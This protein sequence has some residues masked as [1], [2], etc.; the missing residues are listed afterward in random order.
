MDKGKTLNVVAFHEDENDW[1]DHVHLTRWST[2]QE[3]MDDFKDFSS[4]VQK[5]ISLVQEE[6]SVWAIFDTYDNP[7]PTFH[8]GRL[9]VTGD[10]AHATTPHHGNG[11][12]FAIEDS[13]LVAELLADGRVQT[14][15]DIEAV[16]ATYDEIRRERD[17]WLVAS[18]RFTGNADEGLDPELGFDWEKIHAEIK[19]RYEKIISFSPA[20]EAKHA[21][22]VLYSK[23]A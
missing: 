21:K 17:Q 12:G 7:L 18:S 3:A 2:R 19:N 16:F 22:T 1:T 23:L 4:D 8:K 11:A 9:V 15:K 14:P 10:A 6:L 20:D 5:I 13:A